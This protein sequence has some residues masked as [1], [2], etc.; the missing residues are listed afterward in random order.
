MARY[1]EPV[2]VDYRELERALCGL[3]SIEAARVVGD[4]T[5][6]KEVHVLAAPGKSLKQVVR[7]VQ[8]LAMARF[9]V[10][11]DRRAVSVVQ[12][13]DRIEDRAPRP[14]I[15][16]IREVPDGNRANVLVTLSWQGR[17]FSGEA[18]G[19]SAPS[20][21]MRLMGEATLRAVEEVAGGEQAISLDSVSLGALGEH[22]VALAGVVT[23]E[24]GREELMVGSAVIR[25]DPARAAVRA[26]L[27]AVNR[28]MP[29]LAR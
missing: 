9:G 6:I 11:I 16:S 14:A 22:Q 8:S 13:E 7:D 10:S 20:A 5:S 25:D 2:G 27:D 19:S 24:K 15:T 17:T 18:T 29:R 23:L 28:W 21:R 26:V 12:M 4:R 1:V 3:A